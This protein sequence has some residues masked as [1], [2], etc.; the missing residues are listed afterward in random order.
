M[1]TMGLVRFRRFHIKII[2]PFVFEGSEAKL[3]LNQLYKFTSVQ[4]KFACNMIALKDGLPKTLSLKDFLETFLKFRLVVEFDRGV[5][6]CSV[7][8]LR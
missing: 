7:S 3:V 2:V 8:G 1:Q 5:L 4:T 6:H